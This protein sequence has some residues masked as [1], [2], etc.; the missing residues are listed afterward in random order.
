LFY[1]FVSGQ[2]WKEA[3]DLGM[4]NN[5]KGYTIDRKTQGAQFDLLSLPF[6]IIRFLLDL[7]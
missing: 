5:E 2:L 3:C 7:G 1:E 4:D 6:T